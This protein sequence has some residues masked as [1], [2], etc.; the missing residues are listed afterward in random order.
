MTL[1]TELSSCQNYVNHIS[2]F[3]K[4]TTGISSKHLHKIVC[5]QIPVK[6]LLLTSL[7]VHAAWKPFAQPYKRSMHLP[8][9]TPVLNPGIGQWNC[10][11]RINSLAIMSIKVQF[12]NPTD[13]GFMASTWRESWNGRS[14]ET[15][16]HSPFLKALP[17]HTLMAFT[18]T[19]SISIYNLH[20]EYCVKEF[21]TQHI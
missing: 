14:S 15:N 7:L 19:F 9:M 10:S 4:W 5:M 16:S 1:D 6:F 21:V 17:L 13:H 12:T 2:H 11:L 20:Q 3:K 8:Q 18:Y